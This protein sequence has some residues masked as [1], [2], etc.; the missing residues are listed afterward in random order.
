M[1]GIYEFLPTSELLSLG[2]QAACRDE[3][4]KVNFDVNIKLTFNNNLGVDP[5]TLLQYSIFNSWVQF[6][7]NK[8]CKFSKYLIET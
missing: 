7:P 4:M 2:G 5:G 8:H 1:L 3:V 6:S